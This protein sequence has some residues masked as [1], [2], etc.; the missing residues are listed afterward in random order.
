[1]FLNVVMPKFVIKSCGLADGKPLLIA[2]ALQ[3]STLL[4]CFIIYFMLLFV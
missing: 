2:N 4:R 1:M 3:F